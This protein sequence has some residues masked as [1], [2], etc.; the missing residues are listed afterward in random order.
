MA[1]GAR[2]PGEPEL[3]SAKQAAYILEVQQS[4][5]RTIAD[6]PE[7]Y[8]RTA[9]GAIY[10]ADE[11]RAHAAKRRIERSNAQLRRKAAEA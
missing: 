9:A 11:I 3:I 1:K 5:L 8:D 4:N 10:R 6:L 2:Q 7:P